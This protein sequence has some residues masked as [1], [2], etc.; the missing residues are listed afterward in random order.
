MKRFRAQ[1]RAVRL[2][3]AA[4]CFFVLATGLLF[5][6]VDI[7]PISGNSKLPPKTEFG[8][9]PISLKLV[10][11]SL[12]DFFR[13]VSELTGLNILIDP[14]V[15][16]TITINVEEVPWDL[17]FETV[18]RSHGLERTIEGNLVR[19]ATKKTLEAEEKAN[20][21]LKEAAFRATDTVTVTQR[22]N[23]AIAEDLSKALAKQITTRGQIDVDP[24]TNTLILTDVR[25]SIERLLTL[26][27]TLDVPQPQVEIQSRII[28]T[29][30]LFSRRLGVEL[31]F[32]AG[33]AAD[34]VR[35]GFEV[36]AP[37]DPGADKPG[38][39]FAGISVGRL[40]D[41]VQLDALISA[42]ES[43]GD[44][45]LLST[46]RVTTAN[47][48]E[49]TIVQG[50]K[51]PIPVIRNF[52]TTVQYEVAALRLRVTPQITEENTV[53]LFLKVENDVPDFSRTVL[54]IPTILIS[55]SENV[56]L[57]PD[58]GTTMIGG[59]FVEADRNNQEK[60]PGVADLPVI[61]NLFKKTSRSRETREILFFITA[62]IKR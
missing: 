37:L 27:R 18:L 34:R 60:V 12:V 28:E 9:D 32:F 59:I 51:I 8:G 22:L 43:T 21:T 31:F 2:S 57:V 36:F 14:D 38:V 5:A 56:V 40:I 52:Q 29:T 20:Q 19:I 13:T 3:S 10:D 16:G 54:G 58:G 17:L 11:V 44:A 15:K 55:Q 53:L 25:P 33:D 61:G 24:R 41:T 50:A 49:A 4:L 26:V 62:R 46:P 39:G 6:Q 47:R 48:E 35:G 7:A 30:T 1:D 23:Y 45:R 42:G